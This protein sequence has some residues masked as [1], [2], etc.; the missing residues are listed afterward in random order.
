VRE[1]SLVGGRVW[2]VIGGDRQMKEVHRGGQ[3]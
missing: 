2:K 3:V 1:P